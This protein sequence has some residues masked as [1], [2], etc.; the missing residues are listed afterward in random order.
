MVSRLMDPANITE[1]EYNEMVDYDRRVTAG[2]VRLPAT[3]EALVNQLPSQQQVDEVTQMLRQAFTLD[4]A[5]FYERM[6]YVR[7]I[8]LN[9]YGQEH[10]RGHAYPSSGTIIFNTHVV[11][12]PPPE[13]DQPVLFLGL[14]LSLIFH[15]AVHLRD[16]A[17]NMNPS[18]R[19]FQVSE[20]NAYAEEAHWDLLLGNIAAYNFNQFIA[21][22][23]PDN[24]YDNTM[25]AAVTNDSS[26]WQQALAP[27]ASAGWFLTQQ[28]ALIDPR[29]I[30]SNPGQRIFDA[31]TLQGFDFIFESNGQQYQIFVDVS[32]EWVY[33]EGQWIPASSIPTVLRHT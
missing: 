21:D 22:R 16:L 7:H 19:D 15:E 32:G 20:R 30:S 1:T 26:L 24:D 13:D 11:E 14:Q 33:Y 8:V 3:Y 5:R 25:A 6:L 2:F 9:D 12:A 27:L 17:G 31:S 10:G 29:Y 28:A 18:L 23:I 4:P